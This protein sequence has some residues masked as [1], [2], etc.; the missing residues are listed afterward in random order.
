MQPRS[1]TLLVWL[2]SALAAACGSDDGV[3]LKSDTSE[4]TR[5]PIFT[6]L[7]LTPDS[8]L[9]MPLD[10]QWLTIDAW[11]QFGARL[12]HA[13]GGSWTWDA[14]YVSSDSSVAWVSGMNGV[15]GLAPGVARITASLTIGERTHTDSMIVKVGMPTASS[16][17]MT[18]NQDGRRWSPYKVVLKA[19]ATVTWVIPAG[20]QAGPIWL[21]VWTDNPK[22]MWF[23]NG[24]ETHTFSPGVY[25]FGTGLG[26]MWYEE[27][28]VVAVF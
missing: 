10:D 2:S 18:L 25:Y 7:E 26:L 17:V 13:A 15:T 16:A 5:T 6:R 23:A 9:L 20:V 3:G 28:G 14:T 12:T 1:L 21:D 22:R 8:S 11:D 19:P 24:V 27:G 4:A